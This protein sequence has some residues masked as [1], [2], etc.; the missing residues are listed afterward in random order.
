M[1]ELK[2]LFSYHETS[3]DTHDLLDCPCD[4]NGVLVDRDLLTEELESVDQSGFQLASQLTNPKVLPFFRGQPLNNRRNINLMRCTNSG[5]SIQRGG[6]RGMIMK[7]F[8]VI[9][10]K[11]IY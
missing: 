11:M 1:E 9:L 6:K 8:F 5:I 2:R 4:G 7:S 10:L 3:C